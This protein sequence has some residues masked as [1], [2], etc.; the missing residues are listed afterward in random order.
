MFSVF[1]PGVMTAG[2]LHFGMLAGL[3]FLAG[4]VI[5]GLYTRRDDLLTVVTMPPVIFLAAVICVKA[6]TSTGSALISTAEG[7][8]LTLSAA[9]AWLFAGVAVTLIIALCRGLPR[10]IGEFRAALR[11]RPGP[12]DPGDGRYSPQGARPWR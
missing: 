10:S 1:F 7:T 12:A 9:A 8:I 6:I 5:A 3:S 4:C 11:D 2:W